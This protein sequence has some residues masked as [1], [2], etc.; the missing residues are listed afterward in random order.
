MY[1]TVIMPPGVNPIAVN[2]CIISYIFLNSPVLYDVSFPFLWVYEMPVFKLMHVV[3]GIVVS[4]IMKF[5]SFPNK[6]F[7]NMN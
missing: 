6:E 7:T 3:R 2:K 4:A 1:W 5:T